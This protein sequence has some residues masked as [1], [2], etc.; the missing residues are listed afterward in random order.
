MARNTKII[1][2]DEKSKRDSGKIFLVTEM[3]PEKSFKW[4]CRVVLLLIASGIKFP[5]GSESY[6]MASLAGLRISDI[7]KALAWD[8]VEP[9]LDELIDQVRYIPNPSNMAMSMP[10][11]DGFIEELPTI[12]MMHGEAFMININFT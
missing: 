9:L 4:A 1:T 7:T 11:Y 5:E 8:D 3:Q 10:L 6:G 12:A 2:L